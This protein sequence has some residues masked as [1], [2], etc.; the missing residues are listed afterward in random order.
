MSACAAWV[1]D[2]PERGLL[3][4]AAGQPGRITAFVRERFEAA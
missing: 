2:L 4:S 1:R 3:D